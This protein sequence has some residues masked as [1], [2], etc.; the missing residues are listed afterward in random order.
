MA[1]TSKRQ[2]H[3]RNVVAMVWNRTGIL[4]RHAYGALEPA[5]YFNFYFF[6]SFFFFENFLYLSLLLFLL[7]LYNKTKT[8]IN[9]NRLQGVFDDQSSN[10]KKTI[11]F[12]KLAKNRYGRLKLKE[13]KSS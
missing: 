7:L 4:P 13:Q 3:T 12:T 5:N 10:K 9:Y 6:F 11:I 1:D 2:L 8:Q